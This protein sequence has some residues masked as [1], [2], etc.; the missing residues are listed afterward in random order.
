MIDNILQAFPFH[1]RDGKLIPWTE[2]QKKIIGVLVNRR[3][4]RVH[5]MTPTRY[6]KSSSVVAG[7]LLRAALYP[8]KWAIVAG[9]RDKAGIIMQYIIEYALDDAAVRLQLQIEDGGIDRL[10]R[11]RSRERLTFKSKGEIRVYSA[12][13]RETQRM[14]E[15]L[16]GFGAPNVIED[17]AALIPDQIHANVMRMLGDSKDN[18]LCKIGNPF[19]RNHFLKSWQDS[20]YHK[21]FVDYK[22]A[23]EQGRFSQDFIDEMKGQAFFSVLYEVKF[24]DE[25][26]IDSKGWSLLLGEK[27]IDAAMERGKS[28]TPFGEIVFGVD[29]AGGG[30]NYS[31]VVKRSFNYMEKILKTQTGDFMSLAGMVEIERQKEQPK[32]INV[33]QVGIGKGFYDILA[34]PKASRA[35]YKVRQTAKYT[36]SGVN[37]GGK[38]LDPD[39]YSNVRAEMYWALREWI[40]KG[41]ALSKD[42]DWYQLTLIKWKADPAGKL[43]IMPKDEMLLAG[44]NWF[45]V[46]DAGSLTFYRTTSLLAQPDQDYEVKGYL[47]S[48]GRA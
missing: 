17:E 20:K 10:A 28:C 26:A 11:E 24:P 41:G 46:A 39:R 6:G 13:A 29:V 42:E 33:D 25:E 44:N 12:D 30:R 8:E 22:M 34:S 16:M 3:P 18:F 32:T 48:Y 9:T 38:A 14:G 36:I 15:S 37:E 40:L 23:M 45:D 1:S 7:V 43:K 31:V 19:H 5:I 4:R 2:D 27:D 35:E 21:I 47:E